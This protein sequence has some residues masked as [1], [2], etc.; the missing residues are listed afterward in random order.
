MAL[1]ELEELVL[2]LLASPLE[3][4]DLLPSQLLRFDLLLQRLQRA[5]GV[6]NLGR[7]GPQRAV[8]CV[9]RF[10]LFL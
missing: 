5:A 8:E 6:A 9:D 7:R 4:G 2:F 1:L 3:V 10:L